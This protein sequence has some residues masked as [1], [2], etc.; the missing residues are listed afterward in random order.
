M[1]ALWRWIGIVLICCLLLI[2]L[3]TSPANEVF[4]QNQIA[5]ITYH[6]IDDHAQ[7]GVTITTALFESQLIDLKSRGYHFI[8]M[9]QFKRFFAGGSVPDN[10][11]L[12]TF[13]DGY[14][15]FYTNAYPVLRKLRIPA[16]NFVITGDLDDPLHTNIPS[17][18]R[19]EIREMEASKKGISFGCHSDALHKKTASGAPLL[20]NRIDR[21]GQTETDEQYQNRIRQDTTACIRKLRELD[22]DAAE[23]YAYPFGS[24]DKTSTGILREAG[25]RYAFTTRGEMVTQDTDPMQIPRLNAGSPY[26]RSIS[27]NNLILRKIAEHLNPDELIPLGKAMKQL[28]G[29]AR[30]LKNGEIE[31]EYNN[32]KCRILRDRSTVT[33]GPDSFF[34]TQPIV[35]KERHNYIRIQDLQRLLGISITYNP[36]KDQYMKRDSPSRDS[37]V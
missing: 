32:K 26:V 15:S 16:V 24:Y 5:V 4:Y 30:L 34:L 31:L 8:D 14:Q 22:A 29:T 10:A 33:V 13:D 7:S 3:P 1:K 36:V 6:H 17:L 9:N 19:D 21:G 35:M 23:T 12:V 11:I 2:S 27:V 25:I 18:S 20:T 28:G 37:N